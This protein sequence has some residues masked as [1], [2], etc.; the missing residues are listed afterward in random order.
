MIAY[1]AI[2]GD[3]D[4][5]R[6]DIRVFSEYNKFKNPVYNAKIYKILPHKFLDTDISVWMDGN[7]S[8]NVPLEQVVNEWLGDNDIAFF[9]HYKSKNMDW[10]AKWIKYKFNRRSEVYLEALAQVEHYKPLNIQKEEMLM[11]G[12]IIRRHTPLV[13]RFNEAWWAEICRYGERDQLSLP[14]VLRRFPELKV[15]RIDLDIKNNPYLK[16]EPHN[17]D[18]LTENTETGNI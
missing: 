8:L 17:F 10:E 16:Y 9:R 13:E 1:T 3:K 11:G 2:T 6:T 5:A 15:S 18:V 4:K 7:I 12:F 14:V